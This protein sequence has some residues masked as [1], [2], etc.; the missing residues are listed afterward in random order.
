[1]DGSTSSISENKSSGLERKT[2][3]DQLKAKDVKEEVK[4][5]AEAKATVD[6]NMEASMAEDDVERAGGYGATDDIRSFLP[7]TLDSTDFEAALRDAREYEE[8]EAEI[9]RPGLGW[10]EVDDTNG[11]KK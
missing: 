1:M 7:G 6:L 2:N 5:A 9:A 4:S 11:S 10:S 3:E 8:G